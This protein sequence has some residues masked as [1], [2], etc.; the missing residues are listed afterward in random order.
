[1]RITVLAHESTCSS[2]IRRHYLSK[3]ARVFATYKLNKTSVLLTEMYTN[4][5]ISLNGSPGLIS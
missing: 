1:M 2:D 3:A 5:R 4:V